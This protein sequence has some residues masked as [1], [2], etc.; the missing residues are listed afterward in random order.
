MSLTK[1][2]AIAAILLAAGALSVTPSLAAKGGKEK[3]GTAG[4]TGSSIAL[5]YPATTESADGSWPRLGDSVSF[6]TVVAGLAGWE[7]PM[8]AIW[9]YE[10]GVLVYMELATPDSAFILGGG[11]S[12]WRLNG[13]AANCEAYL[14]AYGKGPHESIRTLAGTTF[15]A[16]E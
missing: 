5:N 10:D 15:L 3:P 11:S 12:D 7:Y 2:V 16:A 14:Y 1:F 4:P 9:C 6:S 8:V 13:G